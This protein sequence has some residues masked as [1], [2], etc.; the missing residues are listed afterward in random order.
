VEVQKKEKILYLISIL[1]HFRQNTPEEVLNLEILNLE[2]KD[3]DST[4]YYVNDSKVGVTKGLTKLTFEL[5]D[6]KLG[7]QNL[8]A[9]VFY[10]G[11]NSEATAR[12]EL[13]SSVQPKLL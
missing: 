10:E 5:K 11:Q 12:V 13:V 6:Q 2:S 7:Y 3:V 1:H 8:K 9:L 4:I